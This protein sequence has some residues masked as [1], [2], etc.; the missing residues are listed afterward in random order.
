MASS[1]ANGK[2]RSGPLSC[3]E[4]RRLK[5]RCSRVFPC[6][7]CVKKGCAAICPDGSLTTG[8]GNRFVLANTE[9]LHEKI[10]VLSTRVRELEDALA[11]A[12]AAPPSAEPHPLLSQE[13]LQLKR[14]LE[15]EAPEVAKETEV[16]T[17]EAIDAIGSLYIS[18]SGR[19]KFYGT[20]ANAWYLLQNEEGGDDEAENTEIHL[21]ADIPW[22]GHAFPF[23]TAN[24][25]KLN[26]RQSL[27]S[28]LPEVEKARRLATVYYRHCAWMYT[29][30]PDAEFYNAVFSRIYDQP[31]TIDQDP[32][33][34]HRLA[35]LYMVLALGT[36]FDLEQSYMSVEATQYY[37]LA[38]ASL[39]LD[40]VLEHQTIPAIQALVLMCHFMFMSFRDGPR[41]ALMGLV[42]KLTQSLGLHRDGGKWNLNPEEAYHRRSLLWEVYTYDSWQ[43]LT[44][45]RPPSFSNA[46][47]DCQMAEPDPQQVPDKGE[48]VEMSF[49]A[50]KHRWSSRCLNV[51]HEQAFGAKTPSYRTIQELDKKVRNYPVPPTLRVPGFGGAKM[52]EIEQP[53]IELTMQRHIAFAIKEMT[54]F[55][56]HRGFFARA[57]ED[58]PEDPLG[59]KFAPS[60]LAAYTSACT[61]VGLVKSLH[62]QHSRLTERLWF[63]FT[64]VFSCAIVLGSIAAKCPTMPF[65]RSALMNLD[66][67]YNLFEVVKENDRAAKVLPVLQRLKGRAMLAMSAHAVNGPGPSR[68]TPPDSIVKEE[69]EELA[70]LGGKTRLVPRRSPSTP[71]SPQDSLHLHHTPSPHSSP[72]QPYPAEHVPSAHDRHGMNGMAHWHYQQQPVEETYPNYFSTTSGTASGHWPSDTQYGQLHSPHM[73]VASGVQYSPYEQMSPVAGAYHSPV[74]TQAQADPQAS[75]Q[76]FYAQYQPGS[77]SG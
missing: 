57:I 6:A 64:H 30:I 13:L 62:S 55:Y 1:S 65:A 52:L 23:A 24:E 15:R 36:L 9:V 43:S 67:A 38:R 25:T 60:V 29:P 16:E 20:T 3:A 7:S 56:L 53:S 70:A 69:D 32:V 54:I 51:V 44:F 17:A 63:L 48:D 47:I 14:P 18:E 75:W 42:V 22:L 19:T 45:G 66:S 2:R 41:W 4:C 37:Q 77:M 73:T 33:D 49:K 50:W 26:I 61:F 11:E 59:S 46:Y 74:D 28:S 5:L 58:N 34:S 40:S 27:Y 31:I 68:M 10:L 72:V 8:K 12:H 39:S 71:N 21:P 76:S 35:V